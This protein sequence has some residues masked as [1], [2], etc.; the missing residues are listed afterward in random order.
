MKL[1]RHHITLF[2]LISCLLFN[3]AI[4][5]ES[6]F[7]GLRADIKRADGY[8]ENQNY[9][10]ALDLYLQAE[11]KG[12]GGDEISLKIARTFHQLNEPKE[13]SRWFDNYISVHHSL[14]PNEAYD[15][16]ESL[17]SEEKYE[18][19]IKWYKVYLKFNPGAK[20]VA[21]KIW[22]IKNIEYLFA[23]SSYFDVKGVPFNTE[24]AESSP[25]YVDEK[26]IFISNRKL[27]GGIVTTD[28]NTNQA[29]QALY[30]TEMSF[31]SIQGS[32]SFGKPKPFLKEQN[33]KLHQ[34]PV[35]VSGSKLIFTRNSDGED[36]DGNSTLQL[37]WVDRIGKSWKGEHP[38][39]HNNKNYSISHP[40][41]TTDGGELYFVSDMPGG[42]GGKDLYKCSWQDG[43]WSE[44]QNLGQEINTWGDETSPFIHNGQSLYF[45]SNGH[46]G[47][48][49]LD[50]FKAS[51][52]KGLAI[53][54]QN[55]GYPI[56]TPF[57]DFGL[58]LN[59]DGSHGF[60]ASNR[61]NGG[62]DDDIFEVVVDLQSYPLLISG[63]VKY[64][65]PN[66]SDAARLE[67]LPH[68]QLKLIDN[69]KETIV[70]ETYTNLKGEF[71]ISIPYSSMFKIQV[72]QEKVGQ[73]VVGLEIPKNRKSYTAHEI[74]VIKEDIET[75][76]GENPDMLSR[77]EQGGAK[78]NAKG[79]NDIDVDYK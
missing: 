56:N 21:E 16:A 74:V 18:E 10:S 26:L 15:Y 64:N 31:D 7:T 9:R 37:Y 29:F 28:P 44:P 63:I 24:Y 45:A 41:L 11:K 35:A 48:G 53:D 1:L 17:A 76:S 65:N 20:S 33:N 60:F 68:A 25:A 52:R 42:F 54:V 62:F 77:E 19:A 4:G 36:I 67:V 71:S 38:F 75:I 6:V 14:P 3:P 49:G 34:G 66:W 13:A 69:F 32:Y 61:S 22:R 12:K 40:S 27:K 79:M 43:K 51:L 73:P 78:E 47:F 8:F 57:D 46:A 59:E 70:Y 39:E 50:V 23:D 5:Q 72:M 58:I 55:V 30:F 2:I